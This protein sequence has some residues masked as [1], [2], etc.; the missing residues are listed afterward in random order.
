MNRLYTKKII[1][2]P[3]TAQNARVSNAIDMRVISRGSSRRLTNF[4]YEANQGNDKDGF[5]NGR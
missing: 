2:L 3:S 5:A 1:I 4:Q